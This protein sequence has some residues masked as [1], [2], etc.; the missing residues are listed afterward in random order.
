[1]DTS[2]LENAN[3][4]LTVLKKSKECYDKA[5]SRAERARAKFD[6]Q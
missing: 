1:M 3:L 2:T 4:A 5:A 6:Y